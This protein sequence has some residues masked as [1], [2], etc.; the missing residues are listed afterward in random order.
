MAKAGKTQK[1]KMRKKTQKVKAALGQAKSEKNVCEGP[2]TRV[3]KSPPP[4]EKGTWREILAT[5][6][7]S[8]PL[9]ACSSAEN[10]Q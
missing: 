6:E 3:R 10:P 2:W 5:N 4:Q 8:V 1:L 7:R 9:I